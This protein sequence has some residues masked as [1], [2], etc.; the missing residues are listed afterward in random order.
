MEPPPLEEFRRLMESLG[1]E[2]MF[3]DEKLFEEAAAKV[4]MGIS[5]AEEQV[6]I[7]LVLS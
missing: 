5:A 3:E 6:S 7:K 2:T 1:P 4:G